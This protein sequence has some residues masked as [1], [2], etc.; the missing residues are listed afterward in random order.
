[1][2]VI[3]IPEIDHAY[4]ISM[5]QNIDSRGVLI[6]I[7]KSDVTTRLQGWEQFTSAQV[8]WVSSTK[9]SI[10]GIHR[11]KKEF[12]QMKI[13]FCANGEIADHLVDLRPDSKTYKN[14]IEILLSG[15]DQNCLLIPEGVGHGFQTLSESSEVLYFMSRSYSLLEEL[16]INPEDPSLSINWRKPY[17]LSS[18]DKSAPLLENIEESLF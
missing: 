1:M 13:L 6:E 3:S 14:H 15:I 2:N 8:N 16:T 12:P 11:T 10:R 17:I 7:F 18:K 9:G 4:I 5:Q